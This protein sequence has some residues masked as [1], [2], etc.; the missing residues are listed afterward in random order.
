MASLENHPDKR[1]VY[2]ISTDSKIQECL[3]CKNLPKCEYAHGKISPNFTH[4]LLECLGPEVP[5]TVLV[6]LPSL[7]IVDTLEDNKGLLM[8]LP[9]NFSHLI[10]PSDLKI[11]KF[12]NQCFTQLRCWK[13]CLTFTKPT[14]WIYSCF[15]GDT[16]LRLK[17]CKTLI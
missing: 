13:K 10:Y 16:F 3:T 9:N 1:H 2:K 8:S 6:S 5:Y 14:C 7:E 12:L 15:A 4:F 11:F 17:S